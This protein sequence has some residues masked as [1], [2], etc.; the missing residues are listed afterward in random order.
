MSTDQQSPSPTKT[1]IVASRNAIQTSWRAAN[2]GT[3][4]ALGALLKL[5]VIVYFLFCA[6]VLGVRYLVLPN[7]DS[8]K[9]HIE[10]L[11]SQ[12]LGSKVT[13]DGIGATWSGLRPHLS[14]EMVVIH[15]PAG[16]PSLTLPHVSAIVS[17]WSLIRLDLRLHQLEIGAPDL[18]VTRDANGKLRVAGIGVNG[19]GSGNGKAVEWML[20]QR[21]IVIRDGRLRWNDHMRGAPELMLEDVDFVLHN[22]WHR[23]RFALKATPPAAFSAPLDIRARFRHPH[24]AHASDISRWKGEL[25]VDLRETDLAAWRAY[26]DYP[27]NVSRGS[28]SV[29]AWLD[30]DQTKVADFTADLKLSN[31]SA[32]LRED[33]EPLNLASVSGRM[34]V[35][36]EF[37]PGSNDGTPGFGMNGHTIALKDFT[38]RTEDG[39]TLPHTTISESFVPATA[40]Q[41]AKTSIDAES[42]DLQ[43][44]AEFAERLPLPA[45]QRQMLNDFAPRG[46][47]QDFAAEWQGSY[48]DI[49]AY[50]VKGKFSGLS[51]RSVAKRAEPPQN[52]ETPEQNAMPPLPGFD[53]LSGRI[54]ASERGGMLSLA[55]E[56]FTLHIPGYS[57]KPDI[58][59]EQ[60]SMQASWEFQ[61]HDQL[62]LDVRQLE[63]EQEGISGSFA[64]KHR[65]P[66]HRKPGA[67]PGIIDISGKIN[68]L[69]LQRTG[70]Y[71]PLQTPGP[72]REWLTGA[73]IGGTVKDIQLKLKG[74]LADFPFRASPGNGGGEFSVTGEI[75]NGVLNYGPGEFAQNGKPLWPLI[76]DIDGTIAF[77]RARM[78][79]KADSAKTSG[80]QVSNTKV[81]IPDLWHEDVLLTVDGKAAGPLQSFVRFANDSPVAEWIGYF[82]D[83]SRAGGDAKLDLKLQLP[84]D[85]VEGTTVDGSLHFAG[86]DVT[87]QK[88][89][90]VLSG[91]RGKLSFNEKGFSVDGISANFVGGPVTIS[92]GTQRDGSILVKAD[93]SI[94]ASGI[95]KTYSMRTAQGSPER[96]T[97]S[98]RYA[99]AIQVRDGQPRITVDSG[100]IGIAL[101]FPDP[102]HKLAS[103]PLP[104]RLELG[105]LPTKVPG[106][107]RD[108]I[109][110]SLGAAISAR[111][112]R[113]KPSG[114]NTEWR[115]VRGGIGV[116]VP[117]P[118]PD[119]GLIANVNMRSLNLD[120]WQRAITSLISID[121][122]EDTQADAL[123][124]PAGLSIA[125]YIEP[126]VLAARATELIVMDRK[127]DNV[128]VG[129]SHQN[130]VWQAN[131]DSRQASGY[132]TWVEPRSRQ[133]LGRVTARLASLT[134]PKSAASEVT[135]L[136]EQKNEADR[137]PALDIIVD[138][139]ELFDKQLG[140]LELDA[141][142]VRGE[143]GWEWRINK[144]RI[145]NPDGDLNATGKWAAQGDA[146]VSHLSYV[147]D[148]VDAGRL[149]DRFGFVEVLRGGTGKMTGDIS[150]KGVPF[151][152]DIPSLSGQLQLD[153]ADGQFLKVDQAAQ[154]AAKL[155]G[156]LSLQSLPRRLALDFRDVFSEG[157]AFD[158][159]VAG[160]TID[161]GVA[162][163]DSF[164]M[165]GVSATV[166]MDGTADIVRE[167]QD[168]HVV[169]IPEINAGAAS[170][171]YG[172]AV[173]PVIGVGTFLAQ[174]FLR[175]PLMKAFTFEYLITGPWTEPVV[176]KLKPAVPS[177]GIAGN[178]T[179]DS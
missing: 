93:G 36:E 110:L 152:L 155:L 61:E 50:R 1:R 54:D 170:V 49:S 72:L 3:R 22:R 92:G 24:F 167:E 109:K 56:D 150:W 142:N 66:L 169:V 111:Y 43:T 172:L 21:E 125:Q 48:P 29:R 103:D 28:G 159:V 20:S 119:S 14:L 25:Y 130:D 81:E 53:N 17:W 117:P 154:G 121:A 34:S 83:E 165:R 46:M 171:V 127:L 40:E 151:A 89:L 82:T 107:A 137:M 97:G 112:E 64:G 96:I 98:T 136:L 106:V 27:I 105:A 12:A 158:S 59:F 55:S 114:K 52:G 104:L 176:T 75:E 30:F 160:A 100:L 39:L 18:D 94:S 134:I 144:L 33:L 15:D 16:R 143:A 44:V 179:P 157:F 51:L 79:I 78:E 99:A 174:L 71:L 37:T 77:D 19:A 163:T 135:D 162:K 95:R 69:E 84:L 156:V 26:F 113:E 31:V 166:L 149:L 13:I 63:F 86:N 10:K 123:A 8:Y 60:L 131:I 11:T 65:M 145:A 4:H 87:L 115:V 161:Q 47:L 35:R 67:S 124:Q 102:L 57:I 101:D 168:L 88:A 147:L 85:R 118:Q 62:L 178:S 148:I 5:L 108:E 146:R 175:D 122:P 164:K 129:A 9:P 74:D 42:L 80:T 173:N 128:V 138:N 132:V 126:E 140:R 73:L 141:R 116:N 76:E 6:L 139:F 70:E 153:V 120:A 45:E 91:A 38:L 68:R 133:G 2:T 7:I 23:H 41:P 58:P 177:E 32:R 90:P